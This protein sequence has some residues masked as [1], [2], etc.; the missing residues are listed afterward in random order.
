MLLTSGYHFA[1]DRAVVT[2]R[3]DI[4]H[5]RNRG[6]KK[7]P[8]E[9]GAFTFMVSDQ[10]EVKSMLITVTGTPKASIISRILD[11]AADFVGAEVLRVR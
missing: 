4:R 9:G 10:N 11:R 5:P 1:G 6:Q 2:C 8:P 3:V 7:A